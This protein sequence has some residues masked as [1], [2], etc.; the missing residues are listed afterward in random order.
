MI[1]TIDTSKDSHEGIRKLIKFLQHHIGENVYENKLLD[2]DLPTP[3]AGMFDMF[4]DT[5]SIPQDNTLSDA[6]SLLN[7]DEPENNTN[8]EQ[9][10]ITNILPY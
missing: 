6:N 2:N 9:E 8:G 5:S 10:E 7:D 4:G 1:I 3:S